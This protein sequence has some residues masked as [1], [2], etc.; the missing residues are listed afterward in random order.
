MIRLKKKIWV[1]TLQGREELETVA[2]QCATPTVSS[3]SGQ[4]DTPS[5][6]G[7]TEV[8]MSFFYDHLLTL[9][10]FLF[11]HILCSSHRLFSSLNTLHSHQ[12]SGPCT[13][14]SLQLT[15]HP[16]PITPFGAQF[17]PHILELVP[18]DSPYLLS[19]LHPHRV[20]KVNSLLY[21]CVMI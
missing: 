10:A 20:S 1:I 16:S 3:V 19:D 12:T 17:R 7:F 13:S 6:L 2:K 11:S 18:S 5:A 14:S 9:E 15:P 21:I 4:N 8:R